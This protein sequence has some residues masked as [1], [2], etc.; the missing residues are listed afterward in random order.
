MKQTQTIIFK[1][2]KKTIERMILYN[3]ELFF[4]PLIIYKFFRNKLLE[5]QY[6]K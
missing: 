5:Y 3:F 2:N 1:N 6:E 4:C